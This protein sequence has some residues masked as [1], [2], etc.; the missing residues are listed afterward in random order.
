MI[1]TKD[2]IIEWLKT[3]KESI[4]TYENIEKDLTYFGETVYGVRHNA[5]NYTKRWRELNADRQRFEREG[6]NVRELESDTA[7]KRWKVF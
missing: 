3:I 1:T 2:I 7:F 5:S 6:I 4:I